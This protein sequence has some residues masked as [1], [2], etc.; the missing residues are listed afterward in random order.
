MLSHTIGMRKKEF[1]DM[2]FMEHPIIMLLR[3]RQKS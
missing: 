3:K 1:D 2:D